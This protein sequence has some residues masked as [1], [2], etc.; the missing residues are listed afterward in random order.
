[1]ARNFFP[2]FKILHPFDKIKD[3][4]ER[5]GE[6]VK[7]RRGKCIRIRYK[8]VFANLRKSRSFLSFDAT[9]EKRN[10]EHGS[11]S[12]KKNFVLWLVD[13]KI[14]SWIIVKCELCWILHNCQILFQFFDVTA[15]IVIVCDWVFFIKILLFQLSDLLFILFTFNTQSFFGIFCC[16]K[17]S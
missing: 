10:P 5:D 4:R 15:Q 13:V 14:F 1:M 6:R 9:G 17:L 7:K 16:C 12:R 3:K 2:T 11:S 8:N